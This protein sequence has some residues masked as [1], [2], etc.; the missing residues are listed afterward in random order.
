MKILVAIDG[1]DCSKNAVQVVCQMKSPMAAKPDLPTEFRIISVVDFFEPLPVLQGEKDRKIEAARK[2]VDQT[3][4]EV[5]ETFKEC[6]VTGDVLNGY[7]KQEILK[8]AE[9]WRADLIVVG[10][11]GRTGIAEF[12]IGSISHE[13]LVEAPCATRIVRAADGQPQALPNNV[14]VALDESE[15]SKYTLEHVLQSSFPEGTKFKC[16]TVKNKDASAETAAATQSWL[17][18]SV[19][20]LDEKFGAGNATC[21]T[22]E[23]EP[24]K[25]ITEIASSWPAGLI[26]MGSH[27]RKPLDKLFLGSVSEWVAQHAPCSVEVT[28]VPFASAVAAI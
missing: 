20:K 4:K 7:T 24:E 17:E 21:E 1:S 10:S 12:V 14:L 22:V 25:K 9:D 23:G 5:H 27:G 11:H 15:H 8:C 16:I 3:V 2:L 28:K 19:K 13:V 26:M 18:E 6:S